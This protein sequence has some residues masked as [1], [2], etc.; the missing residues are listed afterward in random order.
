MIDIV[1]MMFM[2][3]ADQNEARA[4]LL[5]CSGGHLRGR[6]ASPMFSISFFSGRMPM[7]GISQPRILRIWL[8]ARGLA[9]W[10]VSQLMGSH[11]EIIPAEGV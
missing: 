10:Q 8:V 11:R 1:N 3:S 2:D 5:R 6:Q 4:H 7:I 9:R